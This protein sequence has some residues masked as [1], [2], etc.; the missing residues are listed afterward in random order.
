MKSKRY[1]VLFPPVGEVN[2][3]FLVLADRYKFNGLLH[4]CM[5]EYVN[6]P[7]DTLKN[8]VD[9][10]TLSESVK[11]IILQ[12]K[13]N[14]LN[15]ALDRERKYKTDMEYRLKYVSPKRRWTHKFDLY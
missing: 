10:D 4:L 13:Y 11:L 12:K 3:E 15:A 1:S 9:S 8:V 14:R 2:E 6:C 7:Q 5:D